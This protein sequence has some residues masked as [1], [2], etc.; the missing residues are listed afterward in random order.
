MC[1]LWFVLVVCDCVVVGGLL[2]WVLYDAGLV[3]CIVAWRWAFVGLFDLFVLVAWF[4][5]VVW[6]AGLAFGLAV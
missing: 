3:G 5:L 4:D 1:V 2:I 6:V